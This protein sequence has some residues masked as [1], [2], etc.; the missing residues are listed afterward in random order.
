M[1][2]MYIL[3][4]FSL[5]I[6]SSSCNPLPTKISTSGAGLVKST[7]TITT[8][9]TRQIT[10]TPSV[11]PSP[12]LE[13]SASPFP[14]QQPT[15]TPFPNQTGDSYSP[16]ISDD[17]RYVV[18]LSRSNHLLRREFPK[19]NWG[20][21]I[22]ACTQVYLYDRTTRKLDLVSQSD[23]GE[24]GNSDNMAPMTPQISANGDW[25]VFYSLSTNLTPEQKE[26]V[27]LYDREA[28]KLRWIGSGAYPKLSG[29]GSL[30]VFE[31]GTQE[32]FVDICLFDRLKNERRD[33]NQKLEGG[34]THGDSHWP[35]ISGDGH[36]LA[37]WSWSDHLKP[38]RKENCAGS[39]RN[40]SCG[41][42]YLWN[43]DTGNILRI[44]IGEGSGEGQFVLPLSLSHDASWIAIKGTVY[45]RDS[46]KVVTQ[47]C[48]SELDKWTAETVCYY[49]K[50]SQDA[51]WI[52]FA[53]SAK[54][55]VMDRLS[56]KEE[57]ITVASDGKPG[58]G[59]PF[60][61]AYCDALVI[62]VRYP[63]FGISENGRWVVFS[64]TADNLD[65]QDPAMCNDLGTVW[66]NCSD[67]FIRDR[68]QGVT[69]WIS[70][71]VK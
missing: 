29:D 8:T 43:K 41:D 22:Y 36:W 17:G 19:C 18:F 56:G 62:C 21:I 32:S 63:D 34:P 58:N 60:S 37:F 1:R 47:F 67:V 15:F 46:G 42:V 9:P 12:T 33:I 20:G 49:G 5:I 38:D 53:L 35:A 27:F 30:I 40:P 64:S 59:L 57:L 24:P 28:K 69:E 39:A 11:T 45:E 65:G 68:Q 10:P 13:N 3:V 31:C 61:S 55:Y 16:S 7:V 4:V 26:G 52:A 54:I 6:V 23:Q 25:I 14:M 71:S 70:R 2:S 50:L 48:Q 66:H 44:E 51:N